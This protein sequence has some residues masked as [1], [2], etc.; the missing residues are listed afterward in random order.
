MVFYLT[1]LQYFAD[2]EIALIMGE[3]WDDM[4]RRST[5]RIAPA[6]PGHYWGLSPEADARLRFIDEKYGF[7]TPVGS[8]FIITFD[9]EK[10]ASAVIY[11]HTQPL[12][13]DEAVEIVVAIQEQFRSGGWFPIYPKDNPPFADTPEWRISVRD[14]KN[15]QRTFWQA[16]DRYQAALVMHR[17]KDLRHPTQERYQIIV[18]VSTA[19]MP[20]EA[21]LDN[22]TLKPYL[23]KKP[24]PKK[25]MENF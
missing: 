11:P 15:G 9:N 19:W 7:I 25:L 10:V 2:R 20:S 1:F 16:A 4:R 24:C 18:D 6:I 13:I 5:V 23:C 14:A 17:F 8:F 3:P 21:E 12:L 22:I